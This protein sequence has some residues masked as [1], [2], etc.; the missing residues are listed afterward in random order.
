MTE[1]PARLLAVLIPLGIASHTVLAGS[2]V[3]VSLAALGQ[4]ASAFT[5]GVLMALY[6]L[7][8]MLCAVAAGR[9]SDRIGVRRADARRRDRASGGCFAALV[10]LNLWA[11]Y[12]SATIVGMSFMVFQIARKG[13]PASS[14]V[15]RIGRATSAC[16][17]WAT[18][19]RASSVR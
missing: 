1:P 11:L 19:C 10:S 8:P 16:S 7:L 6:A 17:R 2:R 18:R 4:G 12:A 13:P 15:R 3:A 14:A 9:L 5:V